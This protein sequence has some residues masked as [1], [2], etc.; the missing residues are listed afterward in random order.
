[1]KGERSRRYTRRHSHIAGKR[2]NIRKIYSAQLLFR[3]SSDEQKVSYWRWTWN[4]QG[5]VILAL[6]RVAFSSAVARA[7]AVSGP[8]KVIATDMILEVWAYISFQAVILYPVTI[9]KSSHS[10]EFA[11]SPRRFSLFFIKLQYRSFY[12]PFIMYL[13]VLL[14]LYRLF[15]DVIFFGP[16]RATAKDEGRS[17]KWSRKLISATVP[18]LKSQY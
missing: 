3:Q 9:W 7:P 2:L 17:Q 4:E 12:F 10:R 1:M 8:L 6:P 15:Y 18:E 16:V 11:E 14:V 5:Q 13:R